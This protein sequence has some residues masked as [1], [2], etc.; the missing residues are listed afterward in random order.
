MRLATG[1][2]V[3]LIAEV[4]TVVGAVAAVGLGDAVAIWARHLEVNVAGAVLLIA[5]VQAIFFPVANVAVRNA[6][7]G[8]ALVL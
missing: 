2:T 6:E 8:G 7:G 4:P 3:N 5:A 1:S